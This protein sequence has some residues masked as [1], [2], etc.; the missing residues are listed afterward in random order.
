[1]V[2]VL[3]IKSAERH[4]TTLRTIEEHSMVPL[5]DEGK[6]ET[7]VVF[8]DAPIKVVAFVVTNRYPAML[9]FVS[10]YAGM[11]IKHKAFSATF[12]LILHRMVPV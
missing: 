11:A 6:L 3:L 8:M 9:A 5:L 12:K 4:S 1:M 7:T 10:A 2:H